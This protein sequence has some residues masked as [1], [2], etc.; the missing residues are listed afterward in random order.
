MTSVLDAIEGDTLA[1]RLAAYARADP[2]RVAIDDDEGVLTYAELDRDVTRLA[3]WLT[4]RFGSGPAMVG[5]LMSS[6]RPLVTASVAVARAGLVSVGIDPAFPPERRL[7][8]MADAPIV[9]VLTDQADAGAVDLP[10]PI[11]SLHDPDIDRAPPA[12]PAAVDPATLSAIVYTS[13]TTGT[14]K[15]VMA[16][17]DARIAVSAAL[18]LDTAGPGVRCGMPDIGS[19]G[20]AEG[21]QCMP[22]AM[23]GTLVPFHFATHGLDGLP[24]WL[25]DKQVMAFRG[26]PSLFRHLLLAL[27][28]DRLPDLNSLAIFGEQLQWADIERLR[29]AMA[30]DGVIHNT[31]GSTE[32]SI[33]CSYVITADVELGTGPVP[34]GPPV[35]G[36]RVLLLD[37]DGV[38][39]APGEPGS[40]VAVGGVMPI[41]Y[42]NR[43]ELDAELY[44]TQPDGTRTFRTGDV[45]WLDDDG[46][47]HLGGREDDVVKIAG[48]R[49]ALGEVE[50]VLAEVTGV[51]AAAVDARPD[52]H[53]DLRLSAF[54]V[55]APGHALE[56]L[57]VRAALARRL[58]RSMLPD[59]V[60]V[61]PLLPRVPGGK[62]DRKALAE[63]ADEARDDGAIDGD[64]TTE[65][66]LTR[67]FAAALGLR[68]ADVPADE[69]FFD[70]GGDSLR[71]VRVVLDIGRD[72]GVDLPVSALIE[73]PTVAT[74]APVVRAGDAGDPWSSVLPVQIGG[75]RPPLFMIHDGVGSVMAARPLAARLGP[76]Q[77]VY[78]IRQRELSGR[79]HP[80]ETLEEV[81]TEYVAEIRRVVPD[82]PYLLFGH[83]FGGLMA[84][85]M[86]RQL[87]A[88][89]APVALVGLGDTAPPGLILEPQAP[90]SLPGLV[91]RRRTEVRRE[92]AL[93]QA[94]A[95]AAG[96][97]NFAVGRVRRV[98]RRRRND[99]SRREVQRLIAEDRIVPPE[100]RQV[101]A[102]QRNIA[103]SARYVGGPY[104]GDVLLLH[105][106]EGRPFP[107]EDWTPLI[108]GHLTTV[109]IAADHVDLMT[110]VAI[111]DVARA[112][113]AEIDRVLCE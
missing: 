103:L 22:I 41:G 59:T 44:G 96:V 7:A 76:D 47:L 30:P 78:A 79:A 82:G 109:A 35:E 72:F 60:T 71:A 68:P 94:R 99:V 5:L 27:G 33:I 34:V 13:G 10:G 73:T 106:L 98:V 80:A 45:G 49:V 14:P 26:T 90:P 81:A 84:F 86:G 43:P 2:D 74:L 66:G 37:D 6:A 4:H 58:P 97:G 104:D 8:L 102:T 88:A 42:W 39:I 11:V 113:Q 95:A 107:H 20:A 52:P 50:S 3:S 28:G 25:R 21:L 55:A 112:L 63:A 64:G 93:A 53:G 77:P 87:T 108:R 36:R 62:V 92:P 67:I 32:A 75:D 100:L 17:H 51:A 16:G 83:S 89:G 101:M 54:V 48:N 18:P 61:L 31:F 110:E 38:E 12:P 40:V 105:S 24:T 91:T 57:V 56:P 70:L 9:L 69:D 111:D 1:T 29:G 46:Y 23:G 19:S 85:E 15:G 65:A